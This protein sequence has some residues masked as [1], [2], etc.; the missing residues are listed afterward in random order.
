MV[1][2]NP[3]YLINTYAVV[4][5]AVSPSV[6]RSQEVKR[7]FFELPAQDLSDTL[8]ALA[9]Q[10]GVTVLADST[11]VADKQAPALRGTYSVEEALSILLGQSGLLYTPINGGFAVRAIGHGGSDASQSIDEGIV[12]TG[13]RLRGAPIASPVVRIDREDM[14][15]SGLSGLGDVV[16]NVPQNFGGGQNPGIGMNVPDSSGA[17]VGGGSA[18]NLRGLGSDATLT[19]LNG[20]RLAYTA[21]FQS[22][23]VSG[24]PV[25][26]VDRIEVVP[27]GAS[28]IYGSDAVAGVAN[29]ILRRDYNG[30]ETS[31]RL[32]GTT[33]GGDFQQQ[34][35]ALAGRRWRSG[36]LFAAYEYGSN[37]AIRANQRSY[38]ATRTP[39][40]DLF[41]AMRHHSVVASGHQDLGRGFT[42]EIDGLYNIRWSDLTF[43]TVDGGDL[44]EGKATF[45]SVDKSFGI[46]PTLTL[47]IFNGWEVSLAGTYG[48]ERVT[49]HQVECAYSD[50]DDS[51]QNFYRNI[52]K[53]IEFS[54][55]G[56]FFRLPGGLAQVA[57]GAG[58]RDIGFQRFSGS[59]SAANTIASQDNLFAYGELSLPLIGPEQAMS[60]VAKLDASAALRYERYPGIGDVA[61]PKLSLTWMMT[62]DVSVKG[63]WGKSFRAPT[64]YQQYQPRTVYLYPSSLL[65]ATG[66]VADGPTL[67]VLGGNPT[68]KPEKATTWSTTLAL[69]PASVP[70]AS[71][72]IS[73]FS[74]A[75]RDR[76][77]SPIPTLSQALASSIYSDQ[78]ILN[79][80]ESAQAAAIAGASTFLNLSGAEYD[81]DTVTAIVDN[82]SVNAARE[83]VRGVDI[84][85]RYHAAIAPGQQL[86]MS[87]NIAYLRSDQQLSASQAT[88]DLAGTI[89]HPPHW[90]GQ[91]AV[92]WTGGALTMA[93]N[94]NYIGDVRDTRFSND[95]DVRG[96][97][98]FDVTSRY[99]TPGDG[100]LGGLEI[101]FS[102]QNLF[103]EKPDPITTTLPYDTPYDSTNYS[104]VGRMLA[105]GINRK[106]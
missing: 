16:R 47:D 105:I 67:L 101:S 82:S 7:H 56:K 46:A 93:A 58:Y 5:L 106:W 30:L 59:N 96:M 80:S 12:V 27:D 14:R 63:S 84:L 83:T 48:K 88:Y 20:H 11:M 69:H 79:P 86:R 8:K 74:V 35:G 51:G 54:A 95:K 49:Y 61:T 45:S 50:C 10:S 89:F 1:H 75:Y 70:E 22:V 64:L 34:Y 29:I 60:L 9:L 94:V 38:A 2:F 92:G 76:I 57:I 24:I 37:T 13:S 71:L 103:N 87:I 44:D 43:P 90:R 81:P 21:V 62:Q 42:L 18:V 17:D 4:A 66:S 25:S 73:Y 72:E 32:A 85:A 104:P 28:A 77:V 97:T 53:S 68:L 98:T 65:G 41:P 36:G 26:A 102:L 31:A 33:D 52:A 19:L 55:D 99:Q 39:G 100:P 23:D 78:V 6:A 3:R 15:D 40:L 91:A